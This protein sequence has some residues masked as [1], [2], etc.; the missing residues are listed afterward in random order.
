MSKAGYYSLLTPLDHHSD[1]P[2]FQ[3]E[4]ECVGQVENN[5]G[6]RFGKRHELILLL[7]F[8][9]ASLYA[10]RVNLSVAIVAM[11]RL[12]PKSHTEMM[13][14]EDTCPLPSQEGE[15]ISSPLEYYGGEFDWDE[16][17]QG[18]LLGSFFYG[19]ILTNYLGG[20]LA[21]RMGGGRMIYGCG[22]ALTAILTLLSPLAAWHSKE[23]FIAIRVLEGM[24]EGV[25]FPSMNV[26][27]TYWI[28]PQERARSFSRIV[29]G[30]QFGTVVTL[31]IS[32]WLTQTWLGWP[33]VFYGFGLCGLLWSFFWFKLAY[34]SPDVHPTISY[35]EK[36]YIKKGIGEH[37]GMKGK[38]VPWRSLLTSPPFVAVVV[39]HVGNNWGFYCLLT[40]LPT[41]LK[42]IQHY[43]MK[44]NGVVSATPYLTMWLFSLVYSGLVDRMLELGTLTTKRVRQISMVIGNYLP[45]VCVALV[46]PWAG[47]DK[48]LAVGLICLAVGAS[49]ATFCGFHCAF[50]ELAPNYSGTLSGIS[51]TVATIPGFLAPALTGTIINNQQTLSRWG[52]VFKLVAVVYLVVC[53]LY[54]VFM[55][56]ETQSWNQQHP[57][58]DKSKQPD[59]SNLGELKTV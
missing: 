32:G 27:L 41:Y 10:M 42:N 37:R 47:C 58:T 4:E 34:D 51:N 24:T 54:L 40:E 9:F 5:R 23:A 38:E 26:M 3:K 1:K 14:I 52:E 44:Q 48:H 17:T 15:K 39:T 55:S 57:P 33:S 12:R 31:A 59:R 25:T 46:V 18:M 36:M 8:G 6:A 53:S 20:R 43:D 21:D 22:V 28:P 16:K 2:Q 13:H 50:Q 29:G 56:V 30:C 19:Y 7:F 35:Q 11:V 45:M 49:G